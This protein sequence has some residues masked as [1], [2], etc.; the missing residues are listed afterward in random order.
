MVL[1]ICKYRTEKRMQRKILLSQICNDLKLSYTGSD[2]QIDGLNLGNRNSIHKNIL[3]FVESSKFIEYVCKNEAVKAIIIREELLHVFNEELQDR[4]I[5]CIISE[6]PENMFYNIH[7]YLYYETNFYEKKYFESIVGENCNI[8]PSAI[9]E[10]GVI[11]GSDVIIG[12]NSVVRSGTIIKNRC[13][14][15]SNSVV[16]SEG[17]QIIRVKGINRKIIHC[18]GVLL[19]EGACVGDNTD[20]ANAL[21]EGATYIGK[22]AMIDNLVHVGHNGYVGDNAVITAG[23]ILCGSSIVES[24]AWIGVNSSVLNRVTVGIDSKIGIG[25]VVTRDVP[26]ESLAYGVPAKVKTV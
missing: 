21:F 4:N 12:A 3:S 10:N 7:D 17:F 8:H 20:I 19:E 16:G 14:I 26:N 15:G 23:T 5:T 18:G 1:D 24:G 22:N 2:I 13:K 6:E 9:I 25:S 11:I